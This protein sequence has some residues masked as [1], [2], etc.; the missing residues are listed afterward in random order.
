MYSLY[1]WVG[2]FLLFVSLLS[3]GGCYKYHVVERDGVLVKMKVI[4][5][6]ITSGTK[7]KYSTDFF[8]SGEEYHEK[9]NEQ[10]CD[11]HPVG[12]LVTMKYVE[13]INV[14]L[15]PDENTDWIFQVL[16]ILA[17]IGLS[18]VA[19]YFIRNH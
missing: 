9:T 16:G 5:H 3:L 6:H 4:K 17:L 13:G 19:Y 14:V 2:F 11:N 15:F 8:Y 12:D 18:M 10:F 1:F 7:A